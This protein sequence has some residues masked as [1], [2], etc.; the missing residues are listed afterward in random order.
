MASSFY[1]PTDDINLNIARGLVKGTTHINKFGAVPSMS[2][3]TTGT[4]WDINDT[5]YPWSAFNTASVLSVAAT[6]AENGH[7]VTIVGLDSNYNSLTETV[8]IA[9]GA[10]TTTKSFLRAFRAFSNTPATNNI[11]IKVGSTIVARILAGN[12]QTLMAVYTIPA[13]HTGYIWK[14]TMTAQASADATGNMF[15]RYFGQTS[16]RI[17]H[18]FEVSGVGG[19]YTYDFPIPLPIPE[20][21]DIDVRATTR[22]NN[23][24]YTAVFDLCIIKTGLETSNPTLT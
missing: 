1:Y 17:G 21:T 14:G 24:R 9:A 22:T 3:H 15:I 7:E 23:G 12:A 11:D 13:G 6:T 4:V 18:S 8:T 19:P 2:T 20:K 10:A 16:F 5:V